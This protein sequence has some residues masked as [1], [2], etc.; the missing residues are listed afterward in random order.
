VTICVFTTP[1]PVIIRISAFLF[2]EDSKY[3]INLGVV[4]MEKTMEIYDHL[5]KAAWLS[6]YRFVCFTKKWLYDEFV[7]IYESN[8]LEEITAIFEEQ[9]RGSRSES[10]RLVFDQL[11]STVVR[12][13]NFELV[14]Q[15]LI[16]KRDKV[17]S[18][19]PIQDFSGK[20]DPLVYLAEQIEGDTMLDKLNR[21]A[22]WFTEKARRTSWKRYV[23]FS[24]CTLPMDFCIFSPEHS[25]NISEVQRI[26]DLHKFPDM[27][28]L[29]FDQEERVVLRT[30]N[31]QSVLLSLIKIIEKEN[32][33]L[34]QTGKLYGAW[35]SNQVRFFPR[36]RV[37]LED[38]CQN[39]I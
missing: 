19:N 10:P 18:Y 16:N 20:W 27:P 6:K 39:S 17:G 29:I 35:R 33:Y 26:L 13:H 36:N 5:L 30:S 23:V 34:E 3:P 14:L 12:C 8:S 2:C 37:G 11:N 15:T 24:Q 31:D 7:I 21:Y 1:N 9:P 22:G 4:T 25:N 28:K 32:S 38:S